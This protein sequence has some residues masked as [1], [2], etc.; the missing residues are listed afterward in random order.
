MRLGTSRCDPPLIHPRGYGRK[1]KGLPSHPSH[2][3]VLVV[4]PT[5]RQWCIPEPR[6]CLSATSRHDSHMRTHSIRCGC[7]VQRTHAAMRSLRDRHLP[8]RCNG[9]I[10]ALPQKTGSP[11]RPPHVGTRPARHV[12]ELDV[13]RPL[14]CTRSVKH[15]TAFTTTYR[16]THPNMATG[17]FATCLSLVGTYA[18]AWA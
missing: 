3:V 13:Q 17:P 4:L 9:N 12:R 5:G 6:P 16:Y 15:A 11:G 2:V 7:C 8:W 1:G 14:L 18:K 10:R